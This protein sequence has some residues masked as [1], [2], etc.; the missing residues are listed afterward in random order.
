MKRHFGVTILIAMALAVFLCTGALAADYT[1]KGTFRWEIR[2]GLYYAYDAKTGALIRDCRVGKCY[3]DQNGTRVLNQFVNG[4]YYN[5]KGNARKKF[6]GGWIQTGGKVY[7]F[8]NR[9]KLTGYRQIG[10]RYYFFSEAGERLSGLFFAGGAYRYFKEDGSQDSKKG[11]RSISQKKY[12]LSEQGVIRE[13]F[14]SVKNDEFYQ[15]VLTGIVTGEQLIDGK[16]YIFRAD[17]VL[18]QDATQ[19]IRESGALGNPSDILFFTKFESGNAGYAQTGGD[20]GKAC[21]KYQF[22]YRYALIPFLKYCYQQDPV[23][24][25]GF[26]DFLQFEKGDKKLIGNAKLYEAWR[27]CY[28][29]DAAKFSSMQD[30]Y[31]Q[32]AYYKAAERMLAEKGIHLE[33]RPYV[34]RGAVF[35]YAI[36]EGTSVAAQAVVAAGLNDSVTNLEFLEKLYD[37]R[38]KDPRGWNQK[39]GFTYRYTEEKRL[40][41][42]LLPATDAVV[43]AA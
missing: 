12:Y 16:R 13:G 14:F 40:A 30:Q 33:A 8:Y 19:R 31:A 10:S 4:I 36:Q 32:E 38:W 1:K 17:G 7:Y 43:P 11:W 24:Y 15:T 6:K 35:S 20:G 37:Y 23:F 25:E 34:I 29:A 39:A 21:G 9:N 3:V 2:D 41:I 22:D 26:K 28:N 27:N 18:D 42:S 5:A